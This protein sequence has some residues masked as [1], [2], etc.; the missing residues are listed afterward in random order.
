VDLRFGALATAGGTVTARWD[1]ATCSNYCH[2]ASLNAGGTNPAPRWTGGAGEA[3]CGSC[4]GVPPPA[5]HPSVSGIDGCAFCHPETMTSA[6]ALIPAASGGK[7]L[8]GTIQSSGH[9]AGWMEFT[10]PAFHAFSANADLASCTACHGAALDGGP[11]QVAC[12]RCHD[13]WKPAGVPSWRQDCTM[14]HGNRDDAPGTPG[15][16]APPRATWG[17]E[18]DAVRVG[19]HQSHVTGSAI[20]PPFDCGVCHVKPD[21]AL[22]PGHVDGPT[23]TVTFGGLATVGTVVPPDWD[24]TTAT[25]GSTYCH[26]GTMG[27]GTNPRPVWTNVGTGEASCGSCHGLPPPA[28]HPAVT[29]IT[30][31]AGCHPDTVDAAGDVIPPAAGGKHLDG[32]VEA[33]SGHGPNWMDQTST[34]FHAYSAD[35]G[36]ASCQACHG[37]RLDALAGGDCASCHGTSWA[38]SCTMC[39]GG[40]DNQ[41]G[42]PPRT[43]YGRGDDAVR[44]GAHTAH[45]AGGPIAPPIDCSACHVVPADA[46]TVGH[47]DQGTATVTF[48]GLAVSPPADAP[49]PGW[50]RA[51]ATCSSTYC[52]GA[53]LT[54]GSTPAPV[55]TGGAS[56]AA[57]GS[58]HGTPPLAPHP[59]VSGGLAGCATCHNGTV[60]ADGTLIPPAS[61]GKHLN[62]QVDA[63]SLEQGCASC[64]GTP[65]ADGGINGHLFHNSLRLECATCHLG[66]TR[67]SADAALHMNGARD[68]IFTYS[69]PNPDPGPGIAPTLEACLATPLT[70]TVR[71][72]PSS[73]PTT[74]DGNVCATCHTARDYRFNACCVDPGAP[75]PDWCSNW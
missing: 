37:Q 3:T 48:G 29:G 28:P 72:P 74:W 20:A 13:L 39:H 61:G 59:A 53:T 33:A 9:P 27:G 44:V 66:Y 45:L 30:S 16:G 10:S 60:A 50:D 31:C 67:T 18:G 11:V 38:T 26:G 57:C 46:F 71:M 4:H 58:C 54:G 42:A 47:I 75:T 69:R 21:D 34:G 43:I 14:C 24:R 5:P 17:N 36:L 32:V 12:A 68:A 64:H 62:G 73:D 56:Q 51:S 40:T 2:G 25:C 22:S 52:H 65:P 41:T 19:A 49:A 55:W 35:A 1:G 23:A 70:A 7:H 15:I 6:G 63:G 8:D